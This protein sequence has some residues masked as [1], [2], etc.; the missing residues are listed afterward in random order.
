M[1]SIQETTEWLQEQ[2]KFNT[3]ISTILNLVQSI[4]KNHN[5]EMKIFPCGSTKGYLFHLYDS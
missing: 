4:T 3:E 5:F 2:W 1:V